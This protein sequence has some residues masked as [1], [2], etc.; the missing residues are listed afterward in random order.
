M[1]KWL[2]L[3]ACFHQEGKNIQV[4]VTFL[5]ILTFSCNCEFF[6]YDNKN[7]K[8]PQ[9]CSYLTIQTSFLFF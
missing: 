2:Y 9:L 8:N 5:T 3:E 6:F 7:K 1:V 4:I